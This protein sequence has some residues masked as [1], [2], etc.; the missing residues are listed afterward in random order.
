MVCH[1]TSLEDRTLLRTSG[2]RRVD[3][4]RV[5]GADRP[6]ACRAGSRPVSSQQTCRR[7]WSAR[8]MS[9]RHPRALAAADP[10]ALDDPGLPQ[11]IPCGLFDGPPVWGSWSG[12][13]RTGWGEVVPAGGAGGAGP[14]A[15]RWPTPARKPGSVGRDGVRR[16]SGATTTAASTGSSSASSPSA[17]CTRPAVSDGVARAPATLDD[18]AGEEP[19]RR[20][21]CH[22]CAEGLPPGPGVALRASGARRNPG[23]PPTR[24]RAVRRSGAVRLVSLEA[25][26]RSSAAH[27]PAQPRRR[28]AGQRRPAPHRLHPPASR[29]THPGVL[30]TPHSGGLDPM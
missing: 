11:V 24:L 14:S 22:E 26:W 6:P 27:A 16:S 25:P 2:D 18:R 19:S 21:R 13:C 29:P 10:H 5:A 15:R 7:S 8:T 23:R 30:R 28:P 17:S 4:R 1:A 3:P 9:A 20:G 12:R